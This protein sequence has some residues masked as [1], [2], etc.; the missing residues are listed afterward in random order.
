MSA[1]AL[2]TQESKEGDEEGKALANI[3]REGQRETERE[4]TRGGQRWRGGEGLF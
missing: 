1:N 2:N 3:K 4:M